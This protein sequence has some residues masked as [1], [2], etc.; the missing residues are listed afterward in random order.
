MSD[1]FGDSGNRDILLENFAAEL[2]SAA[3]AVTLQHG[4]KDQWLDLELDSGRR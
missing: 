3:Y 2:T 4:L 1:N